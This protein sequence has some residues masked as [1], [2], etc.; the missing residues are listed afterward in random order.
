MTNMSDMCGPFCDK[1]KPY[2]VINGNLILSLL[3][4]L[5]KSLYLASHACDKICLMIFHSSC[6]VCHPE[7]VKPV[8]ATTFAFPEKNNH[9][10]M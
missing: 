8:L 10:E 5:S 7:I 3:T 6:C 2:C 4:P 9:R 1:P